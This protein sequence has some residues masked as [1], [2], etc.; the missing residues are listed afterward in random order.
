[1][2]LDTK[3]TAVAYRCPRCGAGIMS[4]VGIFALSGDMIKLKC[5]CGKSEMLL[6]YSKDDK[7]HLT[8]PCIICPKPHN[9]TVSKKLFFS[10]ELFRLGCT[11][12]GLDICFIGSKDAVLEALKENESELLGM[13]EEAGVTSLDGLHTGSEFDN[14]D[15]P[16]I[17]DI[18]RFM[19]V[20][21]KDEGNIHC[22]C[23]EGELSE[24]RFEFVAPD[25]DNVRIYCETCGASVELPMTSLTNANA[26]LHCDELYLK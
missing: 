8:V 26:F 9:Y 21:L 5:D 13:F 10:K 7:V 20:E 12:T 23:K 15:D 17:E 2:I 11:Y 18:I 3:E 6:T 25:Y 4:M 19:L 22:S 24:Y 14:V 1:M 16:A